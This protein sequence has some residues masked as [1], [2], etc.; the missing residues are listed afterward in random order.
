MGLVKSHS[1]YVIRKRHQ[2]TND[3]TIYERDITTIGS[4][5]NFA[6]GQVP[7]YRSGN[8]VITT[9]KASEGRKKL[10]GDKWEGNGDSEIW[11]LE[12]MS[13]ETKKE[14]G[15]EVVLKTDFGRF[16]DFCYYGSC[17]EL[18]RS[19]VAHIMSIFPGELYVPNEFG[20][21]VHEYMTTGKRTDPLDGEFEPIGG[22][23]RFLL[24]NPFGINMHSNTVD[25][26]NKNPLKYFTQNG[27][28]NYEVIEGE[29]EPDPIAEWSSETYFGCAG[30]KVAD[31]SITTI[32]GKTYAIE[33]YANVGGGFV[34]T[35]GQDM[36][37]KEVHI[38]PKKSFYDDFRKEL[39]GFESTILN[40]WS[41]PKYKATFEVEYET[42]N[43]AEIKIE[44]FVYPVGRGGYNIGSNDA[45]FKQYADKLMSIAEYYDDEYCDNLVKSMT[46]ES[47]SNLAD[48]LQHFEDD[49]EMVVYDTNSVIQMLRVCAREFDEIKVRIDNIANYSIVTYNGK[50]NAPDELVKDILEDQEGWD[51]TSVVP[52]ELTIKDGKNKFSRKAYDCVRAYS[53]EKLS[54]PYGYYPSCANC[55][56]DSEITHVKAGADS[57]NITT[58]CSGKI[59]MLNR[60]YSSEKC[61]TEKE[62]DSHFRRMLRLNSR[63][64]LRKKGTIEGIESM[65][66]LF[67][68]KSKRW[69]ESLDDGSL[70]RLPDP[71]A[72]YSITEYT[73]FT[74]GIDDMY[75]ERV[76]MTKMD[77]YNYTKDIAYDTEEYRNGRYLP[78]Q[79]LPVAYTEDEDGNRKVYPFFAKSENYDGRPHYQMD[80]GWMKRETVSFDKDDNVISGLTN[81]Y[82]E[83]INTT[84]S[85]DDITELLAIPQTA[86][87]DGDIYHVRNISGRYADVDG[88]GIKL[89]REYNGDDELWYTLCTI[90]GGRMLLGQTIYTGIVDIYNPYISAYQK[91]ELDS[92]DDG[93]TVKVYFSD[94]DALIRHTDIT[95]DNV[96]V[97][98]DDN[99]GHYFRINNVEYRN[100]ISEYGW[101]QLTDDDTDAM[102]LNSIIEH[103]GGNNQHT[104]HGRY[105]N[106]YRY[107]ANF[108]E[109]F[110]FPLRKGLFDSRCY[111]DENE[112]YEEAV[113][114]TIPEIGFRNLRPEGGEC[115]KGYFV[116]ED[117][118]IHYFGD[119]E[120]N[121][122]NI[123]EYGKDYHL[124]DM[125]MSDGGETYGHSV[126]GKEDGND[127]GEL[128]KG[129]QVDDCVHQIVNTKVMDIKFFMN[130]KDEGSKEWLEEAKYLDAAVLPY[131]EQMVPPT[132]ICNVEYVTGGKTHARP[133]DY[134]IMRVIWDEPSGEDLDISVC[135]SSV[136]QLSGTVVGWYTCP[137]NEVCSEYIDWTDDNRG[138]G[139]EAIF[140][141]VKK[142]KEDFGLTDDEITVDLW[143][144]WYGEKGDGNVGVEATMYYGGTPKVVED[145]DFEID[146]P[147]YT[148]NTERINLNV[149]LQ[150]TV[151]PSADPE[152][153]FYYKKV[154]QHTARLVY[155]DKDRTVELTDMTE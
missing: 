66:S 94:T 137:D 145:Y 122:G 68:M 58:D 49:G 3:G 138:F 45:T 89:N 141:N 12:E 81:M 149:G 46:H 131:V 44:D 37:D 79:G 95:N 148:S 126:I 53:M 57:P 43:G 36:V 60:Q 11:T 40:E 105:D 144:R 22:D 87:I 155:D 86:L 114:E 50:N 75:S 15:G 91:V 39:D 147:M 47:I 130:A 83:T 85:V 120:D 146:F 26:D 52:F 99:G 115:D 34:Y 25:T 82:K 56:E 65:L 93:T 13:D 77:W 118:K 1:N 76:G 125:R 103:K 4:R 19:S 24:E 136:P 64:I 88:V 143:S 6:P 108:M 38:R 151:G 102:L 100:E 78:Y 54:Y 139:V 42:E 28:L 97:F 70:S 128:I 59:R 121:D 41:E 132:T 20:E 17:V 31:I 27:Y 110:N 14:T 123:S 111:V 48:K 119:F 21:G 32:G 150:A 134:I 63:R 129:A 107:M 106:G 80:G 112:P 18:V 124:T 127:V 71:E 8:F 101:E 73:S 104:G 62:T 7:M 135:V 10:N 133:I 55:G 140:V 154:S 84:K 113:E 116:G 5:D 33:A 67:G 117:S 109:I 29:G 9:N 142:I 30:E 90:R 61:Y 152:S 72:D 35:V 98:S 74:N 153:A 69:I 96:Q 23:D 16:T 51:L 2:R 92:E